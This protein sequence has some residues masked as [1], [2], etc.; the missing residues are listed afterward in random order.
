ME[1]VMPDT[2]PLVSLIIVS[3]NTKGLL[4]RCLEDISRE[5]QDMFAEIMVVDNASRD[6]S[7]DMV[8][9]EFPKVK[10]IRS[11]INL[12]FAAANNLAFKSSEGKYIVLLNS[13][14]FIHSGGLKKALNR[15]QSSPQ[16][17]MGGARLVGEDSSWQPSSRR[18]PSLLNEFLQLSG[19]AERYP[20]S[21]LCGRY[22]RTC[23]DQ[24][25]ISETDWVP[26]AFAVIPRCVL[27]KVGFFDEDFFLY[28]EEVD[29]C[30]RMKKAGFKVEYWPDVV[31]THVGGASAKIISPTSKANQLVLWALRSQ[32]L[33][34]RKHHGF[35]YTWMVYHCEKLWHRVRVLKNYKNIEKK[36]ESIRHLALLEQ[37]W[38]DTQGGTSSPAKPW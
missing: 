16:I 26:G 17:G 31:V 11:P 32:F 33:Y 27:E 2:K 22:N 21:K 20:Q 25:R 35:F 10:L 14:A 7:A 9:H 8:A 29:L 34:Y 28:Y 13:D 19:L 6:N 1:I 18:F 38:Q 30:R 4:K 3:F 37:A 23:E 15:I 12:G 24:D 5:V 36:N